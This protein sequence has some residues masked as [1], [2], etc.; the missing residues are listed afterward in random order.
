MPVDRDQSRAEIAK[1]Y[2]SL[3]ASHHHSPIAVQMS[4]AGQLF[5][6]EKLLEIDD[7]NRLSV[8]DL[9]CGCGDLFPVIKRR[10]P[11]AEYLGIDV[12]DGMVATARA[13][14]PAGKFIQRDVLSEGI[15][16]NHDYVLMS[17][18]FN[19]RSEGADDFLR[20]MVS[21]AFAHASRGIAFNFI[22]TYVNRVDDGLA[23]HDP[24]E[25][26]AFVVENLTRRVVLDHHYGRCDVSVFAYR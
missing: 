18:L 8:V 21:T 4:E 13:A 20:L 16:E 26:L 9:G 12:V 14:Y 23:Y 11:E 10:F 3:V 22:S 5:R 1:N 2:A 25:V 19:D 15:G 17:A 6:F 24:S 7:L